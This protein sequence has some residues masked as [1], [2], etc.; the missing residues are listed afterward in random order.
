M[1][2]NHTRDVRQP[3]IIRLLAE[4]VCLLVPVALVTAG[5]VAA[6]SEPQTDLAGAC[7]SCVILQIPASEAVAITGRAGELAGLTIVVDAADPLAV[8]ALD[9]LRHL[10]ATVGVAASPGDSLTADVLRITAVLVVRRITNTDADVFALRTL[11]IAAR[12]ARRDVRILIEGSPPERA[13]AYV[14]GSVSEGLRLTAPSTDDLI[15]ASRAPGAEPVL[16]HVA[17]AGWTSLRG[18]AAMRA[19]ATEVVASAPLTAAQ[20]VARHQAQRRHQDARV[21]RTIARGST[22]LLFE[23]PGIA[24]PVTITAQTTIFRQPGVTEMEQWDIRVN[25]AAVGGGGASS[26]PQLP[27]IEPERVATPPLVITLGDDYQYSLEGSE[28]DG[29]ARVFVVSFEPRDKATGLA[30]GRAWI[31]ATSFALRRLETVQTDLRGAIVSSE[32]H[33]E[34]QAF[35]VG[36]DEVWLPVRTR[37]YQMYEGAGHRTPI[38]R[39][40]DTREY[41]IDPDDFDSRL[42]AAYASPHIMLRETPQGFRY[43]LRDSSAR[44][45]AVRAVAPRAGER[46]RTAV[47]GVLIDPGI[48]VPLPFAGFSYV[49]LNLFDTGAQLNAFFGGAYGQLSW[50]VPSL[51]GTRWQA[52]GRAFAIAARYNDRL[53]RDGVE[54]YQENLTQRP[55]HVSAGVVHPLSP[56]SRIRLGYELDYTAL[57]RADTTA[58]TFAVP[59]DPLVHGFVAAGEAEAGAW[60]ATA[61]WNPAR[62][63]R[64]PHAQTRAFQRFG[65]AMAR[66]LALGRIASS[67]VEAS[68]S[69][70]TDLDRFSR[71]GFDAFQHRLTGYPTATIRYDRGAVLR[72]ATSWA[73]RGFRL[74]TFGDVAAVEDPGFGGRNRVYPGIGAAVEVGGPARTLWSVEWGHGFRARRSDGRLGTHS[75]R[76]TGFRVF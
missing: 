17:K 49:D 58:A 51:G 11:S 16:L 5:P 25:G 56:R 72:T 68:W 73:G 31:D 76:V 9:R 64:W 39:T 38:H 13:R 63:Q 45:A 18:F 53:F 41:S 4:L 62:R 60:T 3:A 35:R 15:A 48:T 8:T 33:E 27:L 47:F 46:I 24:A 65:V 40:I 22:T 32:Q 50:S 57:D 2:G 21:T 59:P 12:A 37:V 6:A 74:D 1:F 43:L 71:Y 66:T 67:R 42:R 30:R 20:V 34:L 55:A 26:P 28:L 14:D 10:G 52:H 23:V 61:W 29:D 69:G 36:V 75:I 19:Y 7:V 70:G 54:Q 44:D